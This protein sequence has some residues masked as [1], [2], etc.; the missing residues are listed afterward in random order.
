MSTLA[1]LKS[2]ASRIAPIN[3]GRC[4]L[5]GG[6]TSHSFQQDF[7]PNTPNPMTMTMDDRDKVF[8]EN[9][10][11]YRLHQ[12]RLRWTLFGAYLVFFT[13]V[14][15]FIGLDA[16]QDPNSGYWLLIVA[17]ASAFFSMILA[18]ENWFYV[19]FARYVTDCEERIDSQRALRT[20]AAFAQARAKTIGPYHHS[21]F[22]V[23]IATGLVNTYYFGAAMSSLGGLCMQRAL[24]F[25]ALPIA[26][27]TYIILK[28]WQPIVYDRFLRRAQTLFDARK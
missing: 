21:Y 23:I 24:V 17:F 4:R 26:A 27:A 9:A 14:T 5:E 12:D 20:L 13:A 16:Y 22:F 2:S 10:N 18:V 6:A 11:R 25:A 1:P 3:R 19:L 15:P 8:F 7:S 28:F